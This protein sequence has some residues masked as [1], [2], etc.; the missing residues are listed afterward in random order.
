MPIQA[1]PGF[2]PTQNIVEYCIGSAKD[3]CVYPRILQ[4]LSITGFTKQGLIGTHISPGATEEDLKQTFETLRTGGGSNIKQWYIVGN[5]QKHFQDTK[6]GWTS[7][8]KIAKRLRKEFD[9]GAVYQIA[10][11]TALLKSPGC[12]WGIDI[13]AKRESTS[14]S[15]TFARAGGAKDKPFTELGIA[16]TIV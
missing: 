10:D 9:S 5:F 15:Y 3:S 7:V 4:C 2:P 14:V 13:C 1:L 12:S 6:V 16:L 11:T 8:A